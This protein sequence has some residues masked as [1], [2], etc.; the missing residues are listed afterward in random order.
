MQEH[1]ANW[2]YDV[3]LHHDAERT[4]IGLGTEQQAEPSKNSLLMQNQKFN[5]HFREFIFR[6]CA[7]NAALQQIPLPI[8]QKHVP[9]QQPNYSNISLG[10]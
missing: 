9:I 7:L 8:T 1:R 4:L 3:I 6:T 5:L 10:K 2:V